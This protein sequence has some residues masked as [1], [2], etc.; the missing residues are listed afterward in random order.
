[1]TIA[2]QNKKMKIITWNVNGIRA[3]VGKSFLEYFK[4]VNADIFCIQETKMQV[5]Q[6]VL[7]LPEYEQFWHSAVKKGYSGTAVFTKKEPRTVQYSDEGEG[8]IITLEYDNFF[9]VNAYVPNAQRELTR[10]DYRLKW[11][12]KLREHLLTLTKPVIYCGDLNVAHCEI[13]LKNPKSNIGNAGFTYEERSAFTNLLSAGFID[14]YR[15]L[16]P[17]KQEYTWW[18]YMREARA[19]NIGWRIDYFVLSAELRTKIID[20]EIHTAIEG[21]DHCP[22]QLSVESL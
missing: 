16:Y 22:V 20:C 4:D 13:D 1:M 17:T 19:K 3:C 11:E 9:L 18:S 15:E 2:A 10:L 14:A 5:G 6:L 7:E 21:S 12:E 8:R